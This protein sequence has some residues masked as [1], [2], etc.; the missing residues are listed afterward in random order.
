ML[1]PNHDIARENTLVASIE[2]PSPMP[3]LLAK[4]DDF[5]CIITVG[6]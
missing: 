6:F 1:K 3:C 4:V 5:L 2:Q